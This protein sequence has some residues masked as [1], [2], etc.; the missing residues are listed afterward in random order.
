MGDT[1]ALIS[2]ADYWG[3][4]RRDFNGAVDDELPLTAANEAETRLGKGWANKIN[5]YMLCRL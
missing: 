5:A 4:L 3:Q 1:R 2:E